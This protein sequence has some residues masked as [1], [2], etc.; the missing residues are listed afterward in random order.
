MSTDPATEDLHRLSSGFLDG[1]LPPEEM[2]VFL[3]CLAR[4]P[5]ARQIYRSLCEL[6]ALLVQDGAV[7]QVLA[8]ADDEPATVLPLHP[9]QALPEAGIHQERGTEA[10]RPTR[11]SRVAILAG[12]AAA[13]ILTVA[14]LLRSPETP[15]TRP[16]E[17]AGTAL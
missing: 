10:Q 2:S 5:E 9:A 8:D 4:R 12:L 13:V 14:Y 1:T 17:P 16:P 11:R 3:D 6:E 7:R 15:L